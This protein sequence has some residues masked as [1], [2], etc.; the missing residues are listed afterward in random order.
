MSSLSLHPGLLPPAPRL[1]LSLAGDKVGGI[2]LIVV[3]GE[4]GAAF[5]DRRGRRVAAA[6]HDRG[7]DEQGGEPA[8]MGPDLDGGRSGVMGPFQ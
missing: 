8:T 6:G 5:F 2:D 3:I 4:G 7:E 1:G